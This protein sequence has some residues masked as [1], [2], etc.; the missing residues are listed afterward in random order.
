[1][2][3]Q[4]AHQKL[5]DG[6]ASNFNGSG[7]LTLSGV[8]KQMP[9]ERE[10]T[11]HLYVN[12]T[13]ITQNGG[14]S[15]TEGCVLIYARSFENYSYGDGI[16]ATG[17]MLAPSNF[18]DFDYKGYLAEKG[19]YSV[20]IYPEIEVTSEGSGFAP[21]LFLNDIRQ[22]L[23]DS[24]E[25]ILPEPHASLAEGMTLGMR[26][27]IP[28][29]VTEDFRVSGTAH[30]LAISGLH[31]GI[32]AMAVLAIALS[33]FGKRRYY[34]VWF[35]IIFIWLFAVL[36]GFAPPVVRAS[37]MASVFLLAELF[38][39][40]R[41]GLPALTL[42]A[43]IMTA[44]DPL[45]IWSVSF[46]MSFA[47]MA[48]LALTFPL[49]QNTGRNLCAKLAKNSNFTQILYLVSDSIS[50]SLAALLFVIPLIAYYFNSVSLFSPISTLLLLPA[51]PLVIVGT[52]FA[53][54]IGV[55]L[56]ILGQALGI[57]VMPFLLYFQAVASFIAGLPY[58]SFTVPDFNGVFILL[59]CAFVFGVIYF[60]R[61]RQVPS[62]QT[63]VQ[64]GK[65]RNG[66][67]YAVLTT[68]AVFL[69]ALV[70]VMPHA[71]KD[72]H[73]YF[74]DVGEGDAS[75]IQRQNTQI[76]IDGGGGVKTLV[77]EI[78]KEMPILDRN[79]ELLVITH[80]HADHFGGVFELLKRYN[81]EH[82]LLPETC[83]PSPSY[84]KLLNSIK[85]ME[86][87]CS[88]PH[89]S[90]HISVNGISF[91]VLNPQPI[92]H[93]RT[94]SDIDNNG[95]VLRLLAGEISFF[96]SADIQLEAEM[97]MISSRQVLPSTVLKIP[98][99]GS[100]TSTSEEFLSAVNPAAAVISVGENN[101]GHPSEEVLALLGESLGSENVYRTDEYGTLEF[102]TDGKRLWLKTHK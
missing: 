13:E 25:R 61:K 98:H 72:L 79:I 88:Y 32:I 35:A 49:L 71:D 69:F 3:Y 81:V 43:V 36:A 34:Y 19:V 93:H 95:V 89:A 20:M 76:I 24:I 54:L 12:V 39:R 51:L 77:R 85:D 90:E 57:L 68:S 91:N 64:A 26:G 73:V 14:A 38:G 97:Q 29:E 78:S 101:F 99:H 58:S 31:V 11:T 59:Y 63:P 94:N 48:G 56:P 60:I 18:A 74:L 33:I 23:A 22:S 17:K 10:N 40:Q 70:A 27:S 7:E 44:F 86:I 42:T 83:A 84:E 75:L 8:I 2:H 9:E 82:I 52:L 30:L 50:A 15:Q 102:I 6:T 45:L 47:A 53:A 96:F 66:R 80:P 1:M 65:M 37:V 5:S 87:P 28:P 92:L 46:Q 16:N 4:N 55:A 62:L 41:R 21:L 67:K 100:S